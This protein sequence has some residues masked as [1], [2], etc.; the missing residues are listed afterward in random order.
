[1][2]PWCLRSRSQ[3]TSHSQRCLA[4]RCT[5]LESCCC[6]PLCAPTHHEMCILCL[7]SLAESLPGGLL[8]VKAL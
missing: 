5:A 6:T 4:T 3:W 8:L 2:C 1:M 7:S